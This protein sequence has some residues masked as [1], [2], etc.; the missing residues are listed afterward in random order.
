M[1]ADAYVS[2]SRL[3]PPTNLTSSILPNRRNAQHRQMFSSPSSAYRGWRGEEREGDSILP[4]N[5]LDL[6]PHDAH[7]DGAGGGSAGMQDLPDWIDLDR[8][9]DWDRPTLESLRPMIRIPYE[10]DL[11]PIAIAEDGESL[12]SEIHPSYPYGNLHQHPSSYTSRPKLPPRRG[13]RYQPSDDA[14]GKTNRVII[15]PHLAHRARQSVAPNPPTWPFK[16]FGPGPGG[17]NALER[18]ESN[19]FWRPYKAVWADLGLEELMPAG[20]NLKDRVASRELENEQAYLPNT[21]DLLPSD[22]SVEAILQELEEFDVANFDS[23]QDEEEMQ[24]RSD[25]RARRSQPE[26]KWGQSRNIQ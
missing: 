14:D 10:D 20:G 21:G 23:T 25:K 18:A 24:D 1:S 16:R 9:E 15:P 13:N 7:I 11:F 3:R 22:I 4:R 19:R 2:S 5:R 8:Y 12:P 26:W 17:P 6:E